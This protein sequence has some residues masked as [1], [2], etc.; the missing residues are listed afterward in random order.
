MT[1]GFRQKV[2]REHC[3]LKS[4]AWS[5]RKMAEANA[6]GLKAAAV[7]PTSFAIDLRRKVTGFPFLQIL[8]KFDR[9]C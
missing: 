5:A 8:Q 7:R 9:T 2:S 4:L 3:G 1:F 6:T